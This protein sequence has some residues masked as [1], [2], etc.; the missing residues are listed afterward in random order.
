MAEGPRR[1]LRLVSMLLIGLLLV[2]VAQLVQVQVISHGFYAEWAQEQY[3]QSVVIVEPPRGVIRDRN[4]HLL[5]GNSVMYSIEADPRYVEDPKATAAE[6]SVLLHMP[7][8]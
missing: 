5:A 6:L 8:M 7:S 2:I 3:K 4:G 1:R